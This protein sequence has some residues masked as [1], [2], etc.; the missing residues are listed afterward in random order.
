MSWDHHG[1][2]NTADHL[3]LLLDEPSGTFASYEGMIK[4]GKPVQWWVN[5]QQLN[6]VCMACVTG[7]GISIRPNDGPSTPRPRKEHQNFVQFTSAVVLGRDGLWNYGFG[8]FLL[9]AETL[10]QA[11][12]ARLDLME[13]PKVRQIALFGRRLNPADHIGADCHIS[14]RPDVRIRRSSARYG[15][16]G[17]AERRGLPLAAGSARVFATGVNDFPTRRQ[18]PAATESTVSQLRDWFNTPFYLSSMPGGANWAWP[19]GWTQRRAP[20]SQRRGLLRGGLGQFLA[21]SAEVYT[22]RTFSGIAT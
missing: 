22:A 20:Q 2:P 3:L 7:S 14:S 13:N 8:H 10:C 11:T 5:D 15:W 17:R 6:A 21:G 9:L 4:T 19:S 18:A 16:L 12:A 1:R